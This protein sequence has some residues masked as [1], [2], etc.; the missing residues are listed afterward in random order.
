MNILRTSKL[1]SSNQQLII[2][3]VE[4]FCKE[5]LVPIVRENYKNE[6]FNKQ[7]Y[8]EFGKVGI[9][10]ST[11]KGYGCLGESYKT[12]G[13]IA[14]TIEKVDSGF[15][16][17]VSVQSSLVM[18]PI[19]K[20]GN[21]LLKDKYLVDLAKGEKVGSF[22]LTEPNAGSD[23]SQLS[24][25]AVEKDDHYLL[26]GT[27]TWITNSPIADVFVVWAK[28]NN[29]IHGFVLDRTMMG[30]T[31]PKIE[32]KMSLRTSITGM[33]FM[34]D[35]KVPKENKLSVEGYKGPFSCLN[36]A[37]LG[38]AFGVLGA[39]EFCMEKIIEYSKDRTLFNQKL[40]EKQLFQYK[41]AHMISE[42]N[43]ALLSCLHVSEIV[44]EDKMYPEAISLLK[45]NSCSKS[46]DIV[47]ECRDML[48]G[49][50]ITDDYDV[51][52]HMCN[53]ETVKTY[54]G[55][56]DIHSLI[57]GNYVTNMKAF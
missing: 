32:G 53:L 19:F 21:T 49:N 47:R 16:S 8:K 54:E 20:Y 29:T 31:T 41:L 6:Y 17:M 45:R 23:T 30:I 35:V 4:S 52:R 9:L 36:S 44:D 48:G 51:F 38:I 26:N 7:L 57:I 25:V 33:I 40:G 15:R 42:Y 11:I 39:S 5:Q 50:G 18:Y 1:I 3:S 12:Y 28:M 34:D 10:G 22:G 43:L 55:T 24:T 56:H 46:L 2:G 14:K 37:R 13:L 27:K